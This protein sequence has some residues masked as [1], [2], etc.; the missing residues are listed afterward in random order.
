MAGNKPIAAC[1]TG[2]IELRV[3]AAEGEAPARVEAFVSRTAARNLRCF[4]ILNRMTLRDAARQIAADF[5]PKS[6][7]WLVEASAEAI[8]RALALECTPQA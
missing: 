2:D 3:F 8:A 6:P 4:A 5:S 7:A 1:R